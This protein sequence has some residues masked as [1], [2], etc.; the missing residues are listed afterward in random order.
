MATA[1]WETRFIVVAHRG[2]GLYHARDAQ[3]AKVY[4]R[5]SAAQAFCDEMMR[6]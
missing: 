5:E 3:G 2:D 1:K 4:K 6:A